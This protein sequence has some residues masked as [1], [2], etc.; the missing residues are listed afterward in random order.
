MGKNHLIVK[1][2]SYLL[3]GVLMYMHICSAWCNMVPGGG[4]CGKAGKDGIE[5]TCCSHQ[6]DSNHNKNDC[7]DFH[8]AFFK[9]SGQF[10]SENSIEV[11]NVFPVIAVILFAP[12]EIQPNDVYQ[13]IVAYNSLHPPHAITD[14]RIFIQSFQI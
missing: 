11:T 2:T 7:Q 12:A 5:K 10:S 3:I 1:A 6:K 9:V 8:L 4:C 13:N 14:I